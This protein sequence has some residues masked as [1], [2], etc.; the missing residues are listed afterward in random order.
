MQNPNTGQESVELCWLL[1]EWSS[2]S[3][4]M[5]LP[6]ALTLTHIGFSNYWGMVNIQVLSAQLQLW[7]L[8]QLRCTSVGTCDAILTE[9][10][11]TESAFSSDPIGG[12]LSAEICRNLSVSCLKKR[13]QNKNRQ[14]I[15]QEMWGVMMYWDVSTSPSRDHVE[16]LDRAQ[17]LSSP[18]PVPRSP[19]RPCRVPYQV[20]NLHV[21]CSVSKVLWDTLW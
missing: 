12:V 10:G 18:F 9:E 3:H 14:G 16:L 4:T 8:W 15:G 21:S 5:L 20:L 19:C 6:Y 7:Y 17:Y 13:F 1:V 2:R 11:L